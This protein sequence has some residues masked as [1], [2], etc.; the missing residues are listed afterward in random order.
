M[1]GKVFEDSADIYEDQAKVLFDY[2][3]QAAEKIV[4]E[5]TAIEQQINQTEQERQQAAAQAAAAEKQSTEYLVGCGVSVVVGLVLTAAMGGMGAVLGIAIAIVC[6]VQAYKQRGAKQKAEQEA[7]QS[8]QHIVE[9]QEK[10]QNIRRDYRVEHIGV[11]YVP[12]ARRIQEG[13]R[14]YLVDFTGEVPDTQ[15]SLTLINQPDELRNAMDGLQQHLEE[16]PVVES[17]EEVEVVNTSDYSTSVQDVTLH[18]YMGTIDR[19]VRTVRY[20]VGD[21]R[22]V[23]V[24]VPVVSPGSERYRLLSEYGTT[25][26]AGHPVIPVFDAR[27]TQQKVKEFSALGALN[28]RSAADGSGDVDFFVSVMRQLAQSVDLLSRSRTT[29]MTQMIGYDMHILQ[30]V[31]KASYDQYSPVLEAEEIERI[32]TATFNYSDEVSDYRPFSLKESSRV[33]YDIFADAWIAD[34][35]VR[36]AMPFG[37]HQVDTEVLMPVIDNLMQ[38]NRKERLR[39]YADIQNQKTDYLNQWHRDTD[40]FFGRNRTEANSLI[41]RMN[42]AYAE[43]V[44]SYINY[45]QQRRAF[46]TMKLSGSMADAEVEEANNQAEVIAGFQ[47][48]TNQAR[49]KQE[50]FT[51]FMERV[52]EDIDRSAEE[53]GHV[54]YYEA[55]LR[56]SQARDNARAAAN[57]RELDARR[58]R[59]ATVSAYLAQNGQVPPEPQVS[60]RL[61]EDFALDLSRQAEN[62]IR[63][64]YRPDAPR[65]GEGAHR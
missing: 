58:L 61:D 42:E 54:E 20:L 65:A 17:N 50:E 8:A 28:Q 37:M 35:G 39:V 46:E 60:G 59:L 57:L 3:Q 27:S 36:T 2:Y 52:R 45:Q 30:N 62:E 16:M 56:D 23:S 10:W 6:G 9:L 13:D 34:N 33:R 1:T 38:E 7:V 41:Q 63:S 14:S 32:R 12:V 19:E 47:V 11:A 53:F 25:S 26:P 48:Q 22:N 29:S 44:E 51:A 4:F 21:S 18:D 40:D 24:G 55:S 15:F 31:L 49:A 5:E 64:M 43:F